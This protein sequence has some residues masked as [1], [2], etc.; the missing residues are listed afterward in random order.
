MDVLRTQVTHAAG[1]N[2]DSCTSQGYPFSSSI[3]HLSLFVLFLNRGTVL[4]LGNNVSARAQTS[5]CSHYLMKHDIN[6]QVPP[7]PLIGSL[8]N[9]AGNGNEMVT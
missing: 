9:D 1:E 8:S 3:S 7:P 2:P 4:V 6:T 5:N